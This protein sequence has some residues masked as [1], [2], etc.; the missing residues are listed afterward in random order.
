MSHRGQGFRLGGRTDAHIRPQP[1]HISTHARRW[2]RSR[3]HGSPASGTFCRYG[4][5][6]R[7]PT[8]PRGSGSD[9]P[10]RR[11]TPSPTGPAVD[12][13]PAGSAPHPFPRWPDLGLCGRRQPGDHRPGR[14]PRLALVSMVVRIGLGLFTAV[15]GELERRRHQLRDRV[16]EAVG[17]LMGTRALD[18]RTVTL[19]RWSWGWPG[20]P[21]RRSAR[22]TSTTRPT[23]R[24]GSRCPTCSTAPP[25]P[26]A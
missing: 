6:C 12:S 16:V 13:V 19:A 9:E 2:P 15:A 26:H 14:L 20:R 8:P 23:P 22:S 1:P 4:A 25:G 21:P 18:R 24:T 3:C 7:R 11:P 5:P 17:P 10:R